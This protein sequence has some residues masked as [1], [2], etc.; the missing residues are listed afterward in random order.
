MAC[1]LISS[2]PWPPNALTYGGLVFPQTPPLHDQL[3][4]T[5][6]LENKLR[7]GIYIYIYIYGSLYIDIQYFARNWPWY[8]LRGLHICITW[9][10]LYGIRISLFSLYGIHMALFPDMVI[11]TIVL[12]MA[13]LWAAMD[14]PLSQGPLLWRHNDMTAIVSRHTCGRVLSYKTCLDTKPVLYQEGF[15]ILYRSYKTGLVPK[16]VNTKP[17]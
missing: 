3:K 12:G 17:V 11:Q 4:I 5:G 14:S 15:C 8:S 9:F 6:G 13:L 2:Q 7:I 10:S 16:R 1:D